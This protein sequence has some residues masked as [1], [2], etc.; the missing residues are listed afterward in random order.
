MATSQQ[1]PPL[2]N[3]NSFGG[4]SIHSLLLQPLCNGCL[5]TMATFFCPQGGRC[6]EVE[7]Y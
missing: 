1:R 7:L 3:G 6:R 5:S 4:Q 2:Y